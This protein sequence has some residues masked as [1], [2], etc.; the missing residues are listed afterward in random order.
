MMATFSIEFQRSHDIDW[1][2]RIRHIYIHALSFGGLLPDEVNNREKNFVI[3]RHS[4]RMT[5]NNQIQVVVNDVYIERRIRPQAKENNATDFERRKERYLRHFIDMAK[6]GFWSFDRDLYDEKKYHLIAKPL[7]EC[8]DVQ[9]YDER[10]PEIEP[11]GFER[12]GDNDW[13]LL[14]R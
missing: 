3:L 2:A 1:F 4:Y 11:G 6:R 7:E 5:D 14:L 12:N 8:I 13:V 10:M 9:W